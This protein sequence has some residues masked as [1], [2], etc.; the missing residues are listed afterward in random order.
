MTLRRINRR[1]L[2]TL[3]LATLFFWSG[4]AASLRPATV[5]TVFGQESSPSPLT[6]ENEEEEERPEEATSTRALRLAEQ[7]SPAPPEPTRESQHQWEIR[8]HHRADH[9]HAPIPLDNR[10]NFPRRLI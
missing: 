1:D 5:T 6:S 8:T 9:A 3:F 7:I 2:F 4:V 10:P